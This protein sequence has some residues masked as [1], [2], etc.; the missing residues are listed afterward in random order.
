MCI[1]DSNS[2]VKTIIGGSYG[3]VNNAGTVNNIKGTPNDVP[4]EGD[5]FPADDGNG[6]VSWSIFIHGSLRER[7]FLALL[8]ECLLRKKDHGKWQMC[9][10]DRLETCF[11]QWAD[12]SEKIEET[13]ARIQEEAERSVSG[14]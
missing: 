14:S 5:S 2:F 3:N 4:R 6:G 1:R 11:T 13:E 9:I 7:R 12:L 8:N 10:R